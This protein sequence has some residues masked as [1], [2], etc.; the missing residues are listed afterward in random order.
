MVGA[1]LPLAGVV[2]NPEQVRGWLAASCDM[3][4]VPVQV[5]DLAVLRVVCVVIGAKARRGTPRAQ[6]RGG[7]VPRL[8]SLQVLGDDRTAD[9]L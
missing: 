9:G 1:S 8:N 5:E 4:G 2:M 7:G 3:Q 6:A